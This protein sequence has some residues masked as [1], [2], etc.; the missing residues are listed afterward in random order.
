LL[1]KQFTLQMRKAK[2]T[3]L[4]F[5]QERI[6]SITQ[7]NPENL[8]FNL[9]NASYIW[10]DLDAGILEKSLNEIVNRHEILHS[11]FR[12]E[13]AKPVQV[14]LPVF[15]FRLKMIDGSAIAAD[16]PAL[17]QMLGEER[18]QPFDLGQGLPFRAVL[19]KLAPQ[20]HILILIMHQIIFDAESWP[21]VIR[22]LRNIYQAFKQGSKPSLPK[23]VMQYAD[24]AS[25]QRERFQGESYT[26]LEQYWRERFTE[27]IVPMQL[28][29]DRLIATPRATAYTY[30][31]RI[32]QDLHGK[33]KMLSQ[34]QKVS[35]FITLLTTFNGLLYMYTM[36]EHFL[37]FTSVS[38]KNRPEL[39]ALIGLFSNLV[40]LQVRIMENQNLKQLLESVYREVNEAVVHQDL[41]FEK[42]MEAIKLK[43]T[44]PRN[45]YASLFQVMFTFR[46]EDSFDL[47]LGD[48]RLEPLE[49][50]AEKELDFQIHL[51]M[52]E[53]NDH[54]E[55]ALT[56]NA[57][58]F[59]ANTIQ[60]IVEHY[61]A[62]LES[63]SNSVNQPLCEPAVFQSIRRHSEQLA[64]NRANMPQTITITPYKA[65][66]DET[67]TKLAALWQDILG[68]EK[69]GIHDNFFEL[70]GHSLNAAI[71]SRR[72]HQAFQ[73]EV[74]L[75]QIFHTPTIAGLAQYLSG[76]EKSF[77][78]S[79]P[80]VSEQ[81]Y[82]PL[83]AAQKRIYILHQLE[84]NMI[85]YNMPGFWFIEG[86][87]ERGQ[88]ENIFRDLIERHESLR[89]SF[90]MVNGAP[91]QRIHST[92]EF[93]VNYQETDEES[94][95]EIVKSFIR[96]FDLTRAPL[97][98]IGLAQ[99]SATRHFLMFD[100]SHIIADGTSLGILLQEFIALYEGRRLPKLRIQYKDYAV[101]QNQLLVSRD[102]QAN[103]R[104]NPLIHEKTG[105][106][107]DSLRKQEAY[108]LRI[109]S[110]ELPV[111]DLPIDYPRPPIQNYEGDLVVLEL[112]AE[113]SAGIKQLALN[114]GVSL[115]MMLL[116]GF[117]ILLSRCSGQEDI[118]IGTPVAGRNHADLENIIGV[119]INTVV[120]RN[121]PQA[122]L[123]FGEFLEAVKENTLE[124]F[125]NQ[126]Y[127]FETLLEKLNVPRNLS[128]TPLFDV[129]FNLLNMEGF[130]DL[131][132]PLKLSTSKIQFQPYRFENKTAKFDLNFYVHETGDQ[133]VINTQFRINLFL[134]STVEYL[135]N[136]FQRL[137]TAI[138][139]DPTR[140]L[141]E[142]PIFLRKNLNIQRPP[143]VPA[144]IEWRFKENVLRQSLVK[145]FETQAVKYADQIAVKTQS[146]C[147]TYAQLNRQ[148]NQIAR[149]IINLHTNA[150]V[151]LLFEH[152]ASMITGII[153]ILKA[154]KTYVPLDPTYPEE[155]L[156][157]MLN[158]SGADLILTN[159]SNFGLSQKLAAQVDRPIV[160]VNIDA[161][162][163][164]TPSF[165]L[166]LDILPDQIAY[167]LY[168]SGSTGHPKGVIQ[169]HRN[170]L[171]FIQVYTNNLSINHTD[172]LSLFSSYSFDA[173]VMD[174]YGALLNGATLH[175]YSLKIAKG[176]AGLAEWLQ[177]E[178]IT[179]FH[180][181]PTVYRYFIDSLSGTET[182]PAIRLIVMG[183]EAVIQSDFDSYR[184]YFGD[185]CIFVNGL[186]PTEST[187]TLQYLMNKDTKVT[188]AAIPVGYP[189]AETAVYLL[190]EKQ[191]E[192]PVL[193]NGE[194][195]YRSEYLALGYLNL[196]EKTGEVFGTDPVRGSG[197]VYHSGDLG[198]L[199][200]NGL[201]QYI[202]RNDSQV[203]IRGYRI[204][205]GEIENHL[206]KYKA[207]K[208]AVVTGIEDKKGSKYLC[209]YLSGEREL[210][211]QELRAYLSGVLPE[212]MIPSYFVQL[213]K[214]PLTPNGKID[215]KV[216][217]KP[218]VNIQIGVVYEAPRN[219][220]ERQLA[221]LWQEV[222]GVEKVGIDDNFFELGGHSLKATMLVGRI[223]K[224]FKAEIALQQVFQFPTIA[225]LAA[226]LAKSSGS[227][228]ASISPALQQEYY[229]M[230]AAQKRLYFLQQI[231]PAGISYNLPGAFIV[232]GNL[233]RDRLRRTLLKLIQRHE[234]FR[235][236]FEIVEGE[237]VQR[238]HPQGELEIS[239]QQAK[240]Q[241]FS[242]IIA[243][244]IQPFDLRMAPL[245]RVGLIKISA[246]KHLL[247][248][249]MHHIIS[250]GTSYGI[251]VKEFIDGYE[252][253]DWPE[254]RIQY[255][256]YTVWQNEFLKSEA[257]KQ[258]K[259]FWLSCFQ[260]EIPVINLPI[261]YPRPAVQN[262]TGERIRFEMGP[263]LTKKCNQMAME[264]GTT[265]YMIL[266]AVYNILLSKYSGQEDIIVG[267]PVAGRLHPDLE[268][269]IGVFINI[270]AM[271]NYPVSFKTFR[272]FLSDVRVNSL[273][274]YENQDYQF[275]ELVGDLNLRRDLSRNPLFNVMFILQNT[276]RFQVESS[277]LKFTPYSFDNK[278][279]QCDLTLKTVEIDG[280]LMNT[281]EYSTELFNRETI[282]RLIDSLRLI[283]QTV[284][285]N[286]SIT[287]ADIEVL[288]PAEKQKI[289]E[290]FNQTK[291]EYAKDKLIQELFEDRAVKVPDQVAI[292][293]QNEVLTYR[294]LD[295]R[296]NSLARILR[297]QGVNPNQ[298][299]GIMV[300][301]SLEMI[302]G[303]LAILKSGG[304]YLPI[305]PDYP[306][307]RIRYM[308]KDSQTK[309]LLT[310]KELVFTVGAEV[311]VV[312]LNNPENYQ[313][314]CSSLELVNTSEDLAYLIYTSGS[315]G[316][317]KGVM[318]EHRAV[319]NFIAGIT[320]R[321][322]F[323]PVKSILALT[324]ISFDIFG[325]ETLLPLT[326]G[327]SI[328]IA[329]ETAQ[330]DPRLLCQLITQYQIRMLQI[331]PSRL[332]VLVHDEQYRA[333][334][335]N[336]TEIMIG[337]EALPESLLAEIR[338][339]TRAKI[340]NMY[341]PTETTIW[342]TIKDLSAET[343]V[344]IGTPIANTQIYIVDSENRPQPERVAG[345]LCIA[346][347]GLARGYWGNHELSM[348]K[349]VANPFH[350]GTKMYRTGDLARWLPDGN[351]EFLGRIDY[352][353]KIRGY[354]I[355]LGEIE[356]QLLKYETVKA[357]V[358]VAK[359]DGNSNSNH[360]KYLCA[361]LSGDRELSVQEL[362]AY[363]SG[364]LPEYMIPA[365][366]IQLPK[367]PLTPNGKINRKIL[368]EPT[369]NIQTG[370]TY[371]APRDEI[372]T[373]LMALWQEVLAVK[374]FGIHDNFFELGGHSLKA[375]SLIDGLRREFKKEISL[376]QI[377]LTPTIASFA[378]HL[379]KEKPNEVAL[380]I[381]EAT[382]AKIP[383]T[384]KIIDN[385]PS[386][387]VYRLNTPERKEL[388][389][390]MQRDITIN[391]HRALPLCIILA[392]SN[393][394][395]WYYE[396][397]INI[398]SRVDDNGLL[399]V[400]FLEVWAPYREIINEISLGAATMAKETDIIE[401]II[402]NINRGNYL[403]ISV[404]EYDLFGTRQYQKNHF[405]HHVLV[406]G[407]DN[408]ER[409]IKSITYN[410]NGIFGELSFG[411]D[412]FAGAYEQ[413][414]LY[415]R[416]SAPWAS[417]TA[418]QLFYSNGF[419][420]PYPFNI[421]KFLV[422]LHHYL[423][424]MGDD[425]IIYF[426]AYK[427]EQVT[428]GF[429]VYSTV[430]EH[431]Q[432][433]LQGDITVNFR[434]LHLI[435]EQK[436]AIAQRLE[437]VIAKYNI[438][439]QVAN[440]YQGFLKI[441]TIFDDLRLKMLNLQFQFTS[442]ANQKI[443][444]L[445]QRAAIQQMIA[446]ICSIKEQE[447][448]LLLDIYEELKT[449]L[450]DPAT[451]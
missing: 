210:N 178:Q 410:T 312:I 29:V 86:V 82:Y 160:L 95:H 109:F 381:K 306:E 382:A 185:N 166:E 170:V 69:V 63:Y 65:P 25:W 314:D 443:L 386:Y 376:Q 331:T 335:E 103:V 38:S 278:T 49:T 436:K 158:D 321:I 56:Y 359:E 33:L 271:R 148:A 345:E 246:T 228:Y 22:E 367:L 330:R 233:N 150:M 127:Q 319:H 401:F 286:P 27:N 102:I 108:W 344:N 293:F 149:E 316:N 180:S 219:E 442:A 263:E 399:S 5:S 402:T 439:G 155:R 374:S 417:R 121:R 346:G 392:D 130:D 260:D 208:E 97:L 194:I 153:G 422:Q 191:E 363:L 146:Q 248:F 206:L 277:N 404:D 370:V 74:P 412:E 118:I 334:F 117:N 101:W 273:K 302:V 432:L 72:L 281:F 114:R 297:L 115:F 24:Y 2:R 188:S 67:E 400:D 190:N 19:L 90:E 423:F 193:Q 414:K 426:W 296:S 17:E 243:D 41:P 419:D 369:E 227:A 441:I 133:I 279:V 342:S 249:D 408:A 451:L 332:Q 355:E 58:A 204:E 255:K 396:H 397:F 156:I 304:A 347:D 217:P 388:S 416:E 449:N 213:P 240:E 12:L 284:L 303:I 348:E 135:M 360:N 307:E 99:L 15:T 353:V 186:G 364:V 51:W 252:G 16:K 245:L 171:H 9:S 152:G 274:A 343:T 294:E 250:D 225:T 264:T 145:R 288:T 447:R 84:T 165:N 266:L 428:Y 231:T 195:V 365:Y 299:V 94:I 323:S 212:Y 340:Y 425:S 136:E 37:V 40:P 48:I 113:L 201:I 254:L 270:L 311:T 119:F 10:G 283:L 7:M 308:L 70:G 377:F 383:D 244:F 77:C 434:I 167:I 357:A 310:Q 403:N 373:K 179:V 361:Y 300:N 241:Q 98:R 232:E 105:P 198:R 257:F 203:K 205:T 107:D 110:G 292:R 125:E 275:E 362:R 327:L 267:S 429:N 239:C 76:S 236:S 223:H 43:Q 88:L 224:Q 183:G 174:I 333:C 159:N 390:E 420:A 55:C 445:E 289:L 89:T 187:V 139:A 242:E 83:S 189:V 427:K 222:L 407:Y 34:Q 446:T 380:V 18:K 81:E 199:L 276:N 385:W 229:S 247:L 32:E 339:L 394:R 100:M 112:G 272:E 261:D 66:R 151:A 406:Y 73:A 196:P 140:K 424:S 168:T 96:P 75:R 398:F 253:K 154:A 354:R 305:D 177:K 351:I 202:G 62:L 221:V 256:D 431:L 176:V 435:Y 182:F 238:I 26:L 211:F 147:L 411:Y 433:L 437:F 141:K 104:Q 3:P 421:H 328:I 444:T 324:T 134:K 30:Q 20:K 80:S 450:S 184:K 352:Q 226:Y 181:I 124:A 413:G 132:M 120:L 372:E 21:I 268:Q 60:Q 220:M 31:F 61:R 285:E 391:S 122:E 329:T 258:Q 35:L 172:R 28:P 301:R 71:L 91:V 209:A 336:L 418:V 128:R 234:A 379:V 375:M 438:Q 215:R 14:A 138:V 349:F 415:Y 6:W 269:V 162:E 106:T 309:I 325:L 59:T 4:S 371:E 13:N 290:D 405:V 298:P 237:P 131:G 430:L 143:L 57:T 338:K 68:I 87:L 192:V 157:F 395:P 163:A 341:G 409:S 218:D 78:A 259:S 207:V 175:P 356:A 393:L 1:L 313:G 11:V 378:A 64:D 173:A 315:T 366:F 230:S 85:S 384:L 337:G 322:D 368:P 92:V 262:L 45:T 448:I 79:I 137:L 320:A 265:L 23:L 46:Y 93:S 129:M 161:M 287:I 126:D 235:T 282:L 116:A 52:I 47:N 280:K 251:L 326:R 53:K 44:E 164:D 197:R 36:Q 42:I 200:P 169:N 8:S 39:K 389:I 50:A 111:F 144:A 216:L 317:P 214:L 387:A 291:L 295:E 142:Y 123:I 440:R 54:I 358:V 318:I 350:P